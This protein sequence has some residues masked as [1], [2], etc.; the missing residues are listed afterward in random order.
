MYARDEV[1]YVSAEPTRTRNP[2]TME[3]LASAPLIFYDAE[4]ADNDPIR[5]QLADRAQ[6]DGLRLRPRIEV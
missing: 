4:S 1:L 2:V 5:R 3:A 6:A